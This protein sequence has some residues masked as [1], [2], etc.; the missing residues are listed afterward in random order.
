MSLPYNYIGS[1]ASNQTQEFFRPKTTFEK[2][3]LVLSLS[4]FII[5][6]L[7]SLD[8]QAYLFFMIITVFLINFVY[9]TIFS[10]PQSSF[11][12]TVLKFGFFFFLFILLRPE[13]TTDIILGSVTII[14]VIL[15]QK[16]ILA[17]LIVLGLFF[18]FV[19]L[20]LLKPRS[21]KKVVE[22]YFDFVFQ[23]FKGLSYSIFLYVFFD[24]IDW[25]PNLVTKADTFP[26]NQDILLIIG[27]L[28]LIISSQGPEGSDLKKLFVQELF[29]VSQTR[30]ERLRDAI[31][32]VSIFLLFFLK[33]LPYFT[34]QK[35]TLVTV[36]YW[37]DAATILFVIGIITLVLS[38]FEN[39]SEKNSSF[40]KFVNNFSDKVS[41][42]LPEKLNYVK[43]A[44][45][46]AK[47]EPEKQQF[48]KLTDDFP[49]VNKENTKFIAKKNSIAIP[50]KETPEGTAVVFVG[51]SDFENLTDKGA[52]VKQSLEELA[53]TVM[54]P[55]DIWNKANL[56][57][58]VI[59]PSDES[60]K[61]LTLKG[62]ESKEKLL[63]LAQSSLTEFKNLTNSQQF[64]TKFQGMV[65]NY[66]QGKYFVSDTKKGTFV[67]LPG[68][69]VI[70]NDETTFVRVFGIKVLEAQGHTVVNMPFIKVIETPEYQLVNLPGIH[71]IEAGNSNLVNLVGFQILDGDPKQI[72]DA[73]LKIQSQST[74][75]DTAFNQL[76][77]RVDKILSNPDNFLLARDASGKTI[78]L[79]TSKNSDSALIDTNLLPMLTDSKS[80][81]F[82]KDYSNTGRNR[83]K[84]KADKKVSA[85]ELKNVKRTGPKF[86]LDDNEA[87]TKKPLSLSK[88]KFEKL[89]KFYRIAKMSHSSIDLSRLAGLL[90]FG[91]V[92]ELEKWLVDLNIKELHINWEENKLLINEDVV[93]GLE[94]ALKKLE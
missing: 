94:E 1:I 92:N 70:D 65:D 43:D 78:N 87:P 28:L 23:L 2:I 58:E 55:N 39:K 79:L 91:S 60:I 19:R 17:G 69:T 48:F 74:Q 77:N 13:S 37:T 38:L 14:D 47:I 67:R 45:S 75:L 61:A 71:V 64:T 36:Q 40:S 72:E 22:D 51:D 25:V 62:I 86:V 5:A 56:S 90:E 10:K 88:N 16:S 15:V 49:I 93:N 21:K 4:W 8:L 63:S 29:L 57:L 84:V 26:N 7:A 81:D 44:I 11:L 32:K 12:N 6:F 76:E 46:D 66:R 34:F 59:K 20:Q 83:T 80:L 24:L 53:T 42:P 3:Q 33:I 54:I 9:L 27:S 30:F 52:K 50:V 41:G 18:K 85:M 31:L 82:K 89:E 68:I 73:K 35:K